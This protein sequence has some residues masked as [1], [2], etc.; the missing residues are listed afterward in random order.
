MKKGRNSCTRESFRV[1]LLPVNLLSAEVARRDKR[2]NDRGVHIFFCSS[3]PERIYFIFCPLLD[4]DSKRLSL[5][6]SSSHFSP[7]HNFLL[8]QVLPG[9]RIAVLFFISL[10]HFSFLHFL[11]FLLFFLLLPL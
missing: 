4:Q 9:D 11:I 10:F 2:E 5:L 6:H 8:A 7:N 3:Y 1:V